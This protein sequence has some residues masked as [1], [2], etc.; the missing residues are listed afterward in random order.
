MYY[1]LLEPSVTCLPALDIP[2]HTEV[3]SG[4]K[5]WSNADHTIET[6]P[7]FL[8]GKTL[9]RLPKNLIK[10]G[11]KLT[12]KGPP[13]SDVYIAYKEKKGWQ[14]EDFSLHQSDTG[15]EWTKMNNEIVR[16]KRPS[17]SLPSIDSP[18]L[19]NIWQ[20]KIGT[21][22]SICLPATTS[23]GCSAAL[24]VFEC[25]FLQQLNVKPYLLNLL[26]PDTKII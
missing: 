23:D 1:R 18:V 7:A 17:R 11:T 15:E 2:K 19:A 24:F 9:F 21:K 6:L 16:Y 5:L 26:I 8:E 13:S 3:K 22:C 12:V 10:K 25:K 20:T 14:G 4:V